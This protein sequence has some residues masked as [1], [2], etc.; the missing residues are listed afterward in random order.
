MDRR[1]FLKNTALGGSAAAATTL[2]APAYAQGNRTLTMVTTWGRGLAG[3]FDAAQRAAD[4][5]NGM[6]D[7]ALTIEVK[8]AGE[9]V[10]AFEVFD[11]VTAGQADLYHGADYYF[12]GQHP[13][14]AF[15]TSVPFGMT[16][17]ELVNWYYHGEG[18]AFHDELG[19]IFGLK[20]FLA[21]NTGAQ[22]GGWFSKEINGPEDFN[23]LKFRMPGLGG[24]ALG[25]LG[26][27]VQNLPGSEVYQALASGAIDGTEW[28]GPWADEKAGFQEITKTY[29]TAGFHEPGAGLSIGMNRDVFNEL[30]P[31]QQKMVEIGCAEAHQWNLAQFLSNNGAALQR[32]QS[33]GVK[34]MQFPDSVWDAFGEASNAVHQENMGDDIYKR[35]YDSYMA[36]MASSSSWIQKSDGAYTAQ[37]DRV[38]G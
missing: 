36:S 34:T 24:L 19:E 2:A 29:Y 38:L 28:I 33:A 30:T 17:Q 25:K 37:R 13:A 3:V 1:S 21:G 23:G 26:A 15:F 14:Y 35:V 32:L 4:N 16:A 5:I 31:A 11:A 20:S 27:S 6:A 8:G 7:G 12:V 9:L 22:A 18:A 10:G